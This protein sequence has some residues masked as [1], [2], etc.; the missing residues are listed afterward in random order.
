MGILGEHPSSTGSLQIMIGV[1]VVNFP[2]WGSV[3]SANSYLRSSSKSPPKNV[4]VDTRMLYELEGK[5]AW[6][7]GRAIRWCH[8]FGE[9]TCLLWVVIM[10]ILSTWRSVFSAINSH[11]RA[12][13]LLLS[14]PPHPHQQHHT[15]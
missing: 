14:P 8:G 4:G 5:L 7:Y 13:E 15:T 10:V 6:R 11:K 2:I 1:P 3:I 9:E 12:L